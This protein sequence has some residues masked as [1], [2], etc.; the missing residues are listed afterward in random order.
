MTLL[1]IGGLNLCFDDHALKEYKANKQTYN[2][3]CVRP[4][5]ACKH[6][7]RSAHIHTYVESNMHRLI[8]EEVFL[9]LIT[10]HLFGIIT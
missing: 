9:T 4:R 7:H 8:S 5:H 6:L 1:H 10:L 2:E 3:V